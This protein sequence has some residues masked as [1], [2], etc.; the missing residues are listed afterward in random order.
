MNGKDMRA[1][2]IYEIF[3]MKEN[4]KILD[5]NRHKISDGEYNQ[6]NEWIDIINDINTYL[7][8]H[9]NADNVEIDTQKNEK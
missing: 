3:K 5:E 9:T 6:L 7:W 8:E 2:I 1:K 4:K